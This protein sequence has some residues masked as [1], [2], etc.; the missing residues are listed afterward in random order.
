[1]LL[2]VTGVSLS[3]SAAAQ[4]YVNSPDSSLI[5]KE[6][7]VI[8]NDGSQYVGTLKSMDAREILIHTAVIG[9]LYIPKHE[10]RSISP[11]SQ[12]TLS[13]KGKAKRE[14]R[15]ITRYFATTNALPI[16]KGN[17]Y[18]NVTWGLVD[19][20]FHISKNFSLGGMTTP[21]GI[22]LAVTPK[23]GFKVTDNFHLGAGGIV[24]FLGWAQPGI[25]AALGYATGT[26][27]NR[28][29]NIS[30][31][32]GGAIAWSDGSTENLESVLLSIGTNIR[33]GSGAYFVFDSF[34]LPQENFYILV[35]GFR[36]I[37][38]KN[39]DYW[40]LGFTGLVVN[41]EVIPFPIPLLQYSHFFRDK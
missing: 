16:E 25:G 22:P 20:E 41:S 10:I 14:N 4:E 37:T 35:P 33:I 11:A 36:W 15:L 34:M 21:A 30:V 3:Q 26:I 18:L 38:K 9:D 29:N 13:S 32:V 28:E 39:K 27:G 5:G 1:M 7:V 17:D 8:K 40:S 24:G 6:V 19:A 31:A 23:L 2:V 12:A